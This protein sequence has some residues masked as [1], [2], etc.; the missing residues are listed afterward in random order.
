MDRDLS[1]RYLRQRPS[2]VAGKRQLS[3]IGG[4]YTH[5][6]IKNLKGGT[7]KRKPDRI[8]PVTVC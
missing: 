1:G 8:D 3:S 6:K 5:G 7:K 2:A 4:L